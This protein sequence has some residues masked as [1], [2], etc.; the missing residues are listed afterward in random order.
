[1]KIRQKLKQIREELKNLFKYSMDKAA[2]FNDLTIEY[3][4]GMPAKYD[5]H[6]DTH[7]KP[8]FIAVNPDLPK[9]DQ[10][11]VIAREIGRYWHIRR[12]DS[13]FIDRRWKWDLLA[14]VPAETRD[15][16]YRLDVEVRAYWIMYWHG[17]RNDFYK[18]HPKKY[19]TALFAHH[20]SDYIFWKLRILNFLNDVLPAFR[21]LKSKPIASVF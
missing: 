7:E 10:V 3:P 16:I 21:L 6:L 14:R 9:Q 5:G 11:Y 1:M 15:F 2:A 18:H 4:N 8:R 12:K 20:I 19:F 17:G 13:P